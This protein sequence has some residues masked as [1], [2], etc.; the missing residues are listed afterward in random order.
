VAGEPLRLMQHLVQARLLVVQMDG[1]GVGAT[2][3]LVHES[4]IQSWPTLRRWLDE[5]QE[6]SAFLE[7]LRAASRQWQ[8]MGLDSGLLWRG[9]MVEEA[10]RFKR[11][12]RGEL[13][14]LQ[15]EFLDAVLSGAVR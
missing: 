3:E 2:A 5:S 15:R 7:Q 1:S 13:P 14:R 10:R 11:R 6:D 12:Y 8:A 9:D 4:L